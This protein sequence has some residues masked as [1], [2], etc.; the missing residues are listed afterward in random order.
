MAGTGYYGHLAIT[1]GELRGAYSADM[2]LEVE[3]KVRADG[4][5]PGVAAMIL[6]SCH[7]QGRTSPIVL[8]QAEMIILPLGFTPRE[9]GDKP[10]ATSEYSRWH[11]TQTAVEHLERIRDGG[12]LTLYVT[13]TV[14]LLN[15]GESLQDVHQQPIGVARPN[16]NPHSPIWHAGQEQMQVTAETWARRVL[17]PWQQAAAVTL[18]VKL[19]EVG[20]TDDHR[21][22]IRDLSDA[23]QRLDV[24]DWKGSIR[25]SRD[26]AEVLRSMHVEHLNPKKTLRT[27]DEREAAIIEAEQTLIQALFD[28]GS[29]THPDPVLRAIAWNRQHAMLALA[30][31]TAVAQRLFSA[32]P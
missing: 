11:L 23:R 29:A 13:S 20:A 7:A 9:G 30:T 19:P 14:V 6:P 12:D 4:F 22:V 15:H 32:A 27:V 1:L 26:A 25:A 17:T 21:T 31:T 24:G 5:A 18:I 28:Y 3:L 8:G 2:L 16:V 10:Y